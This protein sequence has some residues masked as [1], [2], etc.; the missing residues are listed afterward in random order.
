MPRPFGEKVRD[1]RWWGEQQAHHLAGFA[2]V[3]LLVVGAFVGRY[4][5]SWRAWIIAGF[6]VS[7]AVGIG[8]EV[9][10]NWGDADNDY[11]DAAA[12]VLAWAAGSASAA[13][14]AWAVAWRL[15]LDRDDP[16]R[17]TRRAS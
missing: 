7:L 12:D 1:W 2:V 8:R 15:S 14:I 16:P 9:V 3:A 6:V 17:S 13:G 10:Q 4:R 5:R 11:L